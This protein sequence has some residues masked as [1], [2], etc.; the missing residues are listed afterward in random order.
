MSY[1]V[2]AAVV[3][4]ALVVLGF[5]IFRVFRLLRAYRATASMVSARAGDRVGLLRA[6][7]A[8]VRVAIRERRR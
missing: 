5:V 4:V 3:L 1:V 2:S 7:S 8:A 6:R